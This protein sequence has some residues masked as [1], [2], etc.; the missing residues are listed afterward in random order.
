MRGGGDGNHLMAAKARLDRRDPRLARNSDRAV[1]VEAGDLV[2][3]GVDVVTKEDRL[4]GTGEFPRVADDGGSEDRGTLSVLRRGG[5]GNEQSDCDAGRGPTTPL[6]HQSR[7]M[8]NVSCVCGTACGRQNVAP[9][10][11]GAQAPRLPA[12]AWVIPVAPGT[13]VSAGSRRRRRRPRPGPGIPSNTTGP[14]PTRPRRAWPGA[15]ALAGRRRWRIPALRSP[16][17]RTS[18]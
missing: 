5:A 6:R 9:P 7:S 16:S 8:A 13:D 12:R 14:R 2:L 3:A 1:A 11:N 15:A 18:R 10:A 17:A 4:P